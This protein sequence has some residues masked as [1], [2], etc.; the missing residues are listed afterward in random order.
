MNLTTYSD[1]KKNYCKMRFTCKCETGG[2][3]HSSQ[4]QC[5]NSISHNSGKEISFPVCL[6]LSLAVSVSVFLGPYLSVS[7]FSI[8]L[9]LFV[10]IG[11]C[12]SRYV[13]MSLCP[14]VSLAVSKK[15]SRIIQV[16]GKISIHCSC[17]CLPT[18]FDIANLKV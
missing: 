8:F 11:L 5:Q 18:S 12:L 7:L 6:C 1:H 4:S 3:V 2:V 16:K 9:L 15:V 17:L 10:Y 14:S 13:C